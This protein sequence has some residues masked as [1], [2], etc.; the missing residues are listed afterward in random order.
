V[1]DADK[2]DRWNS[3]GFLGAVPLVETN[4]IRYVNCDWSRQFET[5]CCP[6]SNIE[7]SD[8]DSFSP[9]SYDSCLG[10]VVIG[11]DVKT[12]IFVGADVGLLGCCL[13]VLIVL[14]V[15]GSGCSGFRCV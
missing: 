9:L 5:C 3:I 4:T 14:N 10:V 12:A 1:I 7:G 2:Y 13:D 15:R 11:R 8:D 6:W